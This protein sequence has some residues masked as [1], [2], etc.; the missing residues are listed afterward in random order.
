[1]SGKGEGNPFEQQLSRFVNYLVAERNASPYTVRNYQREIGEFLAFLA[2]EEV[3]N[4]E[5]VDRQLLRRYLAWLQRRRHS[6]ASIAR[7]VY[8]LRAFCRYLLRE[9]E[10]ASSPLANLSPPKTSKRLPD[11]LSVSEVQALLAAPNLTEATGQRDRALLEMLYASGVRVSELVGLD[12]D[13][14]DRGRGEVRVQGKGDKERI[15]FLGRPALHMLEI[16]L[17]D[18]RERLRKGKVT[19]ALFLNRF[20]GRLSARGVQFR[21][22]QYAKR[23]GFLKRVTPHVLRHSFATHILDGG[24]DLRVVQELLGHAVVTSTQIYTHVTQTKLREDYLQAHPR[25]GGPKGAS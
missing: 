1:M 5:D 25:G 16:Y 12:V 15:A 11:F 13:D 9:G 17:Q 21:L 8:E 2:G 14:V 23:A 18:G 3:T 19:G 24:A 4:W 7:R 6:G 20:G 22:R 10:L